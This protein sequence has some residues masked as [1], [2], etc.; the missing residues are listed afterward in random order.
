MFL[1]LP[2]CYKKFSLDVKRK[3]IQVKKVSKL[4]SVRQTLKS[5]QIAL[6]AALHVSYPYIPDKVQLFFLF[7]AFAVNALSPRFHFRVTILSSLI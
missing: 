1:F 4:H 3:A 6:L 5:Y 2:N 7:L